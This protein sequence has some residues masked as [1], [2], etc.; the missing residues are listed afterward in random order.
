MRGAATKS[1]QASTTDASN[2]KS[3]VDAALVTK[4]STP[5]VEVNPNDNRFAQFQQVTDY[6]VLADLRRRWLTPAVLEG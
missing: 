2:V 6:Q 3:A 5:T 1:N 4:Q